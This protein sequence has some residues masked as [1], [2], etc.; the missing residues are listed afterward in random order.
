MANKPVTY[1]HIISKVKGKQTVDDKIKKALS[2]KQ[3]LSEY[4]LTKELNKR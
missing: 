1:Y 4:I 2:L 3:S